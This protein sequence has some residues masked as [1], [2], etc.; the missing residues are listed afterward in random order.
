MIKFRNETLLFRKIKKLIICFLIIS[1]PIISYSKT[2]NDAQIIKY[3][4]SIYSDFLVL[5]TSAKRLVFTNNTPLSVGELKFYLTLFDY[6]SL[7]ENSKRLYDNIHDFLY[8][9]DNLLTVQDVELGIHPRITL[10]GYYKSNSDIPYSFN[11]FFKDNF[12]SLPLDLGFG[13]NFALGADFFLGKS[14]IKAADNS[15]HC[16]VPVEFDPFSIHRQADFYFPTFAYIGFG[17]YYENWGY[18]VHAGKQGKTVGQTLTGS[19]L[20]NST[21]ETDGY[22]EFDIYSKLVK[23]TMD[24]VQVSSNRMDKLQQD[25]TERY[26]YLH[27]FDVNLFKNLKV[28]FLEGSLI[29]APFSIRFLNPFAVMHQ[30]GGWKNYITPEN[31]EIYRE[32]NF[33]ADFAYMLEYIPVKNLRLYGIYNQIEMQL[34]YERG[35]SWGR[36]YPNSIGAQVGAEYNLFINDS[37]SMLFGLEG[38]YNSP[39]MYIKQTPS[40][41]LYRARLDMQTKKYVYSWIGSPFGPDCAGGM[42]KAEY[43]AQKWKLELDYLFVEKGENNK[44]LNKSWID[45][46]DEY[47]DYYPSVSY[48]LREKGIISDERTND[49]L[50]KE[51]INMNV[52]GIKEITNQI[53]L[54]G[55]YFINELFELNG[56]IVYNYIINNGNIKNNNDS[57]VELDLSITYKIF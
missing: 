38:F 28:S 41:S 48:K 5:Q 29:A 35:N 7:D 54:K 27:Q 14:Y 10:E 22:L 53:T 37:S 36:Y 51:A 32:T 6:D 21:F 4:S 43:N 47:Y 9:E 25:N 24:V 12:I 2:I 8:E 13:K 34:S 33:C 39:Y 40:A 15:N 19:I 3:G 1:F 11:Y 55:T 42:F 45:C 30:Y 18:N 49:E 20:Y 26:L 52:S 23:M 46:D 50:Y 56:Q 44:L 31:A 57:G 17:K 16:N